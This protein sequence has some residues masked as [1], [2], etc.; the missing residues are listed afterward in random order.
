MDENFG[1][2]EFIRLWYNTLAPEDAQLL[3]VGLLKFDLEPLKDL[4]VESASL[5]GYALRADL[6]EAPR[7]VD[8]ALV[9]EDWSE[10][11]VT[12]TTRPAWDRTP[13]ATV[14]VFG[15]NQ[16]Y[17]WDVTSAVTSAVSRSSESP[18]VSFVLGMRRTI[19]EDLEEQVVFISREAGQNVPRLLVTFEKD[20]TVVAWWMWVAEIGAAALLAFGIGMLV[21]RRRRPAAAA[22][23]GDTG[24]T[25]N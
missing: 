25:P 5:Q 18:S 9:R 12:Y 11:D 14:A 19:Q 23:G 24:N 16:W 2:L 10:T 20:S 13:F 7:L 8:V 3:S 6:A 22:L 4:K 17:S 21:A 1:Q 15:P